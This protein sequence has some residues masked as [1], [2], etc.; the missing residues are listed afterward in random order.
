LCQKEIFEA[1]KNIRATKKHIPER[2]ADVFQLQNSLWSLLGH[3]VDGVLVAKPVGA[4]NRI[5][6]MVFPHILVHV[7][8]RSID[9]SLGSNCV[10]ARWKE[11]G[12]DSGLE[13]GV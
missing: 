6:E 7:G 12:D 3:I 2:H 4:L 8:Q 10:R 11:L 9:A 5:I 13:A 1:K